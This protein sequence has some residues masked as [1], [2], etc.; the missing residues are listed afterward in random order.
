MTD[1]PPTDTPPHEVAPHDIPSA[2]DLLEA[3][4]E[5]L[6]SD[7]AETTDGRLRFH[8]RVAANVL[9][10]VAREMALGPEQ[11]RSHA[12]RLAGL[13][14]ADDTAL[15]EAI[16]TGALDDRIDEVVDVV[17]RSVAD[18]LAVANP[19]YVDGPFAADGG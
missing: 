3:V 6:Q 10:M 14:V 2:T 5:F 11:A 17:R 16:R 13:G 12:R 19:T 15:A 18:K 8:A 7:V 1:I 9:G 4:R